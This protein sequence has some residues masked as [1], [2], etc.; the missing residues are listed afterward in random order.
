MD[1][2]VCLVPQGSHAK[3]LKGT[4]GSGQSMNNWETIFLIWSTYMTG[5][6][7]QHDFSEYSSR[8]FRGAEDWVSQLLPYV[9]FLM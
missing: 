3:S 2:E 4:K 5:A 9:I 1:T 6:S 8:D 7:F